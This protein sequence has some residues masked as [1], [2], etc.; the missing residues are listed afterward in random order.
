MIL[1]EFKGV[2]SP[3]LDLF[4]ERVFGELFLM[5]GVGDLGHLGTF[6]ATLADKPKYLYG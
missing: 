3:V 6:Q 5:L 1:V 2:T 4:M